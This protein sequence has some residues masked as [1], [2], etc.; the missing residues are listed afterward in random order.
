MTTYTVGTGLG[1]LSDLQLI[2]VVSMLLRRIQTTLESGTPGGWKQIPQ[3]DGVSVKVQVGNYLLCSQQLTNSATETFSMAS[4]QNK[5]QIFTHL[6]KA[7]QILLSVHMSI[8]LLIPYTLKRARKS[9][10]L[11]QN[12]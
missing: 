9:E 4:V 10:S 11:P 7:F 3:H 6:S 1:Q 8:L 12:P 2:I 5:I